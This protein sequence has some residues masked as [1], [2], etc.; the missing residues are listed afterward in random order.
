MRNGELIKL[1]SDNGCRLVRHGKGHDVW[2]S[3]ITGRKFV[4]PRHTKEIA[5]GTAENILKTAGL[6]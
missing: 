2:V 1:L 3:P 5:T 6:K 4:V